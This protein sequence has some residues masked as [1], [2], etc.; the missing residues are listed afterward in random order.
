MAEQ[1]G[2]LNDSCNTSTEI[3]NASGIVEI[4]NAPKIQE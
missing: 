1:A 3:K 4:F 2:V